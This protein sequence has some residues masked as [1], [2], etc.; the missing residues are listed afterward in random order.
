VWAEF[1]SAEKLLELWA[2]AAP[3]ASLN[4]ALSYR[5]IIEN[6]EPGTGGGLESML[7]RW[8]RRALHAAGEP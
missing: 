6:V 8:I 2:L 3:L 7:P 1:A 4:Q 5:S